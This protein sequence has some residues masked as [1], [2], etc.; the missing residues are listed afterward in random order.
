MKIVSWFVTQ[1]NKDYLELGCY[2][3][4]IQKAE[5]SIF[6]VSY[7]NMLIDYHVTHKFL[8]QRIHNKKP[9]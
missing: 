9:E 7:M 1:V 8:S 5:V 3:L 2:I 4:A 6:L